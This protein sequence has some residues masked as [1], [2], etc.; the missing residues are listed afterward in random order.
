MI[1][2]SFAEQSRMDCLLTM[3]ISVT[4]DD[5]LW[6]NY[7]S[8]VL[9]HCARPVADEEKEEEEKEENDDDDEKIGN[10]RAAKFCSCGGI[11]LPMSLSNVA[12][13]TDRPVNVCS[14]FLRLS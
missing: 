12:L 13:A 6:K 8:P 3:H 4:R 7:S 5:G 2:S 14:V 11:K 10:L 1:F 9:P